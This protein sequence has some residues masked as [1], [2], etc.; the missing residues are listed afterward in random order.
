VRESF[1]LRNELTP[2]LRGW[3]RRTS[4]RYRR[5]AVIDS[6]AHAYADLTRRRPA[7][8]EETHAGAARVAHDAGVG[9]PVGGV[10]CAGQAE[11]R[12]QRRRAMD[13]FTL[14]VIRSS[15]MSV[16]LRNVR[17]RRG[18]SPAVEGEYARSA[19]NLSTS[20]AGMVMALESA[21][22]RT[23]TSETATRSS[24]CARSQT[25]E[26]NLTMER[27]GETV[28]HIPRAHRRALPISLAAPAGPP[29]LSPLRRR[30]PC[31]RVHRVSTR[32]AAGSHWQLVM[33]VRIAVQTVVS[34]CA[35]VGGR[36]GLG[37]H[38]ATI[39]SSSTDGRRP[40]MKLIEMIATIVRH[41]NAGA[42]VL[43]QRQG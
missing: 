12:D 25:F 26:R 8:C 1:A 37:A 16:S 27:L 18:P 29:C 21:P 3:R 43:K 17:E 33:A 42:F 38:L 30:R 15:F 23:A 5:V 36:S 32:A 24:F 6:A 41:R 22:R 14:R 39:R 2:S 19:P 9:L 7:D 35:V 10:R 13:R 20:A 4:S 34:G 40:P 11:R 31:L 28:R